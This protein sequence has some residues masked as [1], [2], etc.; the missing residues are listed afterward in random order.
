MT[1]TDLNKYPIRELFQRFYP[2][3]L[4]DHPGLSPEKRRAAQ[5]IMACKTGDL[6][7]DVSV[8]EDCG[9]KLIHNVSC[10]NRFCPSCQ[11][12]KAKQWELE[13]N[14]E[15]IE[16]IAY[17]HVVFTVPHELNSLIS[18]NMKETLNLMFHCVHETLIT[19]CSD[20]R[21]M[22][23]KP[24]IVSV[25]HTWGQQLLFHP[26]IHVCLSGGGITP[27]KSF[28]VTRK[29]GFLMPEAVLASGFRGRFLSGL[30]KLYN[31]GRLDLSVDGSLNDP[32]TWKSFI[33]RLFQKRWLPFVK[34]TFNGNG[35]AIRYLARYS[36]RTA[37]ANSRIVSITDTDVT[38]RYKDY[39]DDSKEKSMTIS[40][41]EF[42]RRYLQHV[43]PKGFQRIRFA[44]YLTNSQKTR[45][46]KLIHAL[47]LSDYTGNPYRSMKTAELMLILYDR[48]ICKCPHCNGKILPFGRE[49]TMRAAPRNTAHTEMSIR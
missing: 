49:Y 21:F 18:S 29:K 2:Q 11:A 6:G 34:E 40:G 41:T 12:S 9:V 8:C 28:A 33:D 31:D 36:Y 16:G 17:Y 37:I 19:L 15:L 24:G 22:G 35:N 1:S 30:K 10:N 38:F 4:E 5:C 42:V 20:K 44:G 32:E 43:L 13:R 23:A 3:Y 48:D 25:L 14:T 26:H 45:N 27:W 47:R 7:Y 39:A 46:L